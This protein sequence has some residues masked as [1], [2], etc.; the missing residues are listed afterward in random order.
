MRIGYARDSLSAPI[1][2]TQINRLKAVGCQ[3][4]FT[5]IR[6]IEKSNVINTIKDF[7]RVGEDTIVVC[8]LICLDKSLK[9]LIKYQNMPELK[10][11][12]LL[13]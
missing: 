9:E 11:K 2:H 1:L 4:I 5:S 8:S 12:T 13:N 3:K 10:I 7:I 6:S